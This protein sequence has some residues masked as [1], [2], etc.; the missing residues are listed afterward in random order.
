VKNILE[1]KIPPVI[2][3]LVLAIM[4][5]ISAK[6]FPFLTL[7]FDFNV[8]IAAVVA[9][10]GCGMVM[11]GS[12]SFHRV[13]TTV[14]PMKPEATTSLVMEGVYRF[15]RNPIYL[16]LAMILSSWGV[17]LSNL[18]S[19]IFVCLFIIYMN[20]FQIRPEERMLHKLFGARF[21]RYKHQVRRWL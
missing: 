21:E 5:W 17:Y 8:V 2:V 18:S 1:L 19:L 14:N 13:G 11:V 9:V 16:G 20:H 4:M 10:F 15:T 12:H 3:L 7:N 6:N